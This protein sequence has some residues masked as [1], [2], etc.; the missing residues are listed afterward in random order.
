MQLS[1]L[2]TE[3]RQRVIYGLGLLLQPLKD[4]ASQDAPPSEGEYRL[5][6][7]KMRGGDSA[8]RQMVREFTIFAADIRFDG[9]YANI[10]H[11]PE[12][13]WTTVSTFLGGPN[14]ALVQPKVVEAIQESERQ[15]FGLINLVPIELQPVLMAAN[16]PFTAYRRISEA[17]TPAAS[18]VHYFDR[19]LKPSFF[20]LFLAEVPGDREIRI[21]TTQLGID[22]VDAVSQLAAVEFRDY[23]LILLDQRHFHDRNLRVDNQVFTLGPGI[24][25]AGIA[26]T[27]FGPADS[28]VTAHQQLDALITSGTAI[29][30]S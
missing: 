13:L 30:S 2:K 23:R 1:G 26:L 17:I 9:E 11:V 19:Y 14:P 10:S 4:L 15:F 16:T 7:A 25:R 3:Q 6:I 20:T 8:W 27:N 22:A 18:R 5:A 21:V 28:S 29:H 12:R 24:D